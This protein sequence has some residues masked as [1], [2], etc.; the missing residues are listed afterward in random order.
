MASIL[1][2][3]DEVLCRYS[4]TEQQINVACS[5]EHIVEIANK[6]STWDYLAF[7]IGLDDTD[8]VAI[9]RNNPHDYRS[10]CL[11]TLLMWRQKFGSNATYLSL[12]KG[13]EKVGRLDLVEAVCTMFQRDGCGASITRSTKSLGTKAEVT[14]LSE[15]VKGFETRFKSLAKDTLAELKVNNVTTEEHSV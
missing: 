13:L 15:R 3:L 12:A 8:I 6:V 2:N 9:E 5:H 14:P 11:A 1:P 10:Q 4:M 7:H